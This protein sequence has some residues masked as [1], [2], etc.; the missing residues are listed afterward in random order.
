MAIDTN[1]SPL[2]GMPDAR[3]HDHIEQLETAIQQIEQLPDQGLRDQVQDI[4]QCLLEFH[5]A[6]LSRLLV[7][8]RQRAGFSDEVAKL[9]AQD[10]LIAS[11]LLLHGLHPDELHTRVAEAL[12]SVRPFLKSHGGNVELVGIDDGV[13]RLRLQGSCHGCPSSTAT[14]KSRIEQ[15]IHEVAPDVLR[16]EVENLPAAPLAEPRNSGGFVSLHVLSSR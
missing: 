16:V 10:E 7:V 12:E 2:D 14:V 4:V 5:G 9:L 1:G 11:L 6:A 3:L 13:V 15:A 8:L